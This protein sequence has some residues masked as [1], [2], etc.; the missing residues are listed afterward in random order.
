MVAIAGAFF[1]VYYVVVTWDLCN[2]KAYSKKETSK[3]S[4]GA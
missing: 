2:P 4:D 3:S 1:V